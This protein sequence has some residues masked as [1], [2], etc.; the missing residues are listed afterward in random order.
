MCETKNLDLAVYLAAAGRL[1]F[2]GLEESGGGK[3]KFFFQAAGDIGEYERELVTGAE[4]PALA[5]LFTLR[6]IRQAKTQF[7]NQQLYP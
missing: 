7:R 3:L 4:A 6:A 5:V 1:Q 2:F